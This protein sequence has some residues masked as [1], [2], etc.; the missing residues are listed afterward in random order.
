M[1]RWIVFMVGAIAV[2]AL[3]VKTLPPFRAK[4]AASITNFRRPDV[5]WF[6]G[7]LVFAGEDFGGTKRRG[8]FRVISRDGY[9]LGRPIGMKR[10]QDAELASTPNLEPVLLWIENTGALRTLFTSVY[11]NGSG[12][13]SPSELSTGTQMKLTEQRP[14][15]SAINLLSQRLVLSAPKGGLPKILRLRMGN[16]GWALDNSLTI[17]ADFWF[18][19]SA[20]AG[21]VTGSSSSWYAIGGLGRDVSNS[22]L[23]VIDEQ[24]KS[25]LVW[26]GGIKQEV[27][28]IATSD[29]ENVQRIFAVV[30][31]SGKD[32]LMVWRKG[33][34]D[35]V[36]QTDGHAQFVGQIQ[37]IHVLESKPDGFALGIEHADL[38]AEKLELL[39]LKG[40][41][42]IITTRHLVPPSTVG[43]VR[44]LRDSDA[45]LKIVAVHFSDKGGKPTTRLVSAP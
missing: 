36:W 13:T 37:R 33:K 15:A 28:M 9:D 32:A 43:E 42:G 8:V 41:A 40:I 20:A 26:T 1:S 22:G 21:G 10:L 23:V 31:H 29:S 11:K 38:I 14:V 30:F 19:S 5:A 16:E 4:S 18:V 27:R 12:W 24:G 3:A 17:P 45:V 2:L 34:Q 44:W 39:E 25:Q 6:K 7:S 35:S